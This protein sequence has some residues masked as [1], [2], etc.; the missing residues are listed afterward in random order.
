MEDNN[1]SHNLEGSWF[2]PA[3]DLPKEELP[4]VSPTYDETFQM[5]NIQVT[6]CA[7]PSVQPISNPTSTVQSNTGTNA[8][9]TADLSIF[10][11]IQW[12][13]PVG[14]E[15]AKQGAMLEIQAIGKYFIRGTSL[16]VNM[17]Y[18]PDAHNTIISPTAIVHQHQSTFVGRNMSMWRGTMVILLLS[19]VMEK[20]RL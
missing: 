4:S 18:C 5:H 3:M 2:I 8:C 17:Y 20:I 11:N 12:V 14:C 1:W 16:S 9:I 15:T 6:K 19:L 13:Q 10:H 7:A